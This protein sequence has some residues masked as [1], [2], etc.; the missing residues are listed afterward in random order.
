IP[1]DDAQVKVH[2]LLDENGSWNVVDLVVSVKT[3]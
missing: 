3:V 1:T 2:L